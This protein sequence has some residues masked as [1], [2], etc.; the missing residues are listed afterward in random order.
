MPRCK[1]RRRHRW[2]PARLHCSSRTEDSVKQCMQPKQL[3]GHLNAVDRP[4]GT[5]SRFQGSPQIRRGM[6]VGVAARN[7]RGRL[8]Y[9]GCASQL[10]EPRKHTRAR[11]NTCVRGHPRNIAWALRTAQKVVVSLVTSLQNTFG[12]MTVDDNGQTHL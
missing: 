1:R 2:V 6:H 11:E 7:S 4:R 5:S 10:T 8:Y 9:F 3:S 12:Y